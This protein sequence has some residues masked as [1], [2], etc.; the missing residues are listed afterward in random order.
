MF[1]SSRDFPALIRKAPFVD[2]VSPSSI[3]QILPAKTI[4]GFLWLPIELITNWSHGYQ[5]I[6]K[7]DVYIHFHNMILSMG[8]MLLHSTACWSAA[9][10]TLYLVNPMVYQ[11]DVSPDAYIYNILFVVY[12]V[13]TVS[14]NQCFFFFFSSPFLSIIFHATNLTM[15]DSLGN[16]VCIKSTWVCSAWHFSLFL[17]G[18]SIISSFEIIWMGVFGLISPWWE[19]KWFIHAY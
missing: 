9:F 2:G 7:W 17:S 1:P 16:T 18:G 8:K 10:L 14:I 4:V 11:F 5:G 6:L 13:R 3:H 12:F 19:I 15:H